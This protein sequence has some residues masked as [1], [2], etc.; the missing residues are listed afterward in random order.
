MDCWGF[1]EG[2]T[3]A[4]ATLEPKAI[5]QTQEMFTILMTALVSRVYTVCK[6]HIVHFKYFQIIACT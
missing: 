3:S 1:L 5:S 4:P 2:D 6:R